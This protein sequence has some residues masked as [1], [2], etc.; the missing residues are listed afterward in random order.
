MYKFSFLDSLDTTTD[1]DII[2]SLYDSG[3]TSIDL[4]LT[5]GFPGEEPIDICL[6]MFNPKV[7]IGGTSD[8]VSKA[9]RK[10]KRIEEITKYIKLFSMA[11]KLYHNNGYRGMYVSDAKEFL[12]KKREQNKIETR[13]KWYLTN[14]IM[15]KDPDINELLCSL[16]YQI[17]KF[18]LKLE[19]EAE[20]KHKE[21]VIA[22]IRY[23]LHHYEEEKKYEYKP[24][25][26]PRIVYIDDQKVLVPLQYAHVYCAGYLAKLSAIDIETLKYNFWEFIIKI[27]EIFE[28]DGRDEEELSASFLAAKPQMTL[29]CYCFRA[30]NEQIRINIELGNATKE[31][32]ARWTKVFS[33]GQDI[34]SF[35]P[36]NIFAIWYRDM[37][38]KEKDKFPSLQNALKAI[39]INYDNHIEL[40][41][42]R[43]KGQTIIR[44]GEMFGY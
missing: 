4:P 35:D 31:D 2:D 38:K 32:A 25:N 28:E 22:N 9:Y 29:L 14:G 40:V 23:R 12:S 8:L 6:S 21:I 24:W 16:M 18:K 7:C 30:T 33:N 43:F 5:Y 11:N 10:K 41:A 1:R 36:D 3:I 20:I 37:S 42:K 27:K 26:V 17:Y 15:D 13:K 34:F 19:L 44:T 39:R